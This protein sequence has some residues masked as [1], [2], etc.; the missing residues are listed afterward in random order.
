MTDENS[1]NPKLE[2]FVSEKGSFI[3]V[4]FVGEITKFTLEAFE[5][6]QKELAQKKASFWVLNLRDVDRI[7]I[8]AVP[9]IA[10]FQ[11]SIRDKAAHLRICSL[12]P[13]IRRFLVNRAIL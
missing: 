1:A 9:S 11:K 4:S 7:D 12:K 13:E 10:K 3:V 8:N 5:K 2:Y 6:C